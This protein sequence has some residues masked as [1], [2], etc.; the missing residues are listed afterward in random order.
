MA[1]LLQYGAGAAEGLDAM[2]EQQLKQRAAKLEDAKLA[3]LVRSHT[4]DETNRAASLADSVAW[5][6]QAQTSLDQQ[7]KDAADNLV[8]DNTRASEAMRVPGSTL[9]PD[10][11][12]KVKPYVPGSSYQEKD[13]FGLL[14]SPDVGPV[15]T[16]KAITFTGF[17][18]KDAPPPKDPPKWEKSTALVT[19]MNGPQDVMVNPEGPGVRLWDGTDVTTK[20]HGHYQPPPTDTFIQTGDSQIP[21]SEAMKRFNAGQDLPLPDPQIER[22]RRGMAWQIQQHFGDAFD[23]LSQADQMGLLGPLQGRL[24]SDFLARG[25]GSTGD[26]QKDELLGGL[27]MSLSALRSGFSSL[28]GRGGANAAQSEALTKVFDDSKM[29][30]PAIEGALKEMQKWVQGYAASPGAS[31]PAPAAG[32]SDPYTEYLNRT[33]K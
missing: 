12:N 2:M 18:P 30:K 25:V 13:T 26:P 22:N 14:P 10:E 27:R 5:R 15:Q 17:K 6:Q 3:E 19:G 28:H 9:T 32:G 7:R 4:A 24:M 8:A 33:G 31:I 11:F 20:V 16:G 23:Q 1:N 21:R 29:S